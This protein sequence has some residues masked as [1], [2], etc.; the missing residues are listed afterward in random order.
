MRPLGRVLGLLLCSLFIFFAQSSAQSY[1]A[2]PDSIEQRPALSFVYAKAAVKA[3]EDRP[4]SPE[5][6]TALY[7]L[8]Q[9]HL[10]LHSPVL[11]RQTFTRAYLLAKSGS[12][13]RL[14]AHLAGGIGEC[15]VAE[16]AF[17][18][19]L[20]WFRQAHA[21]ILMQPGSFSS[22]F[23]IG[24]SDAN[25]ASGDFT[26]A[27]SHATEALAEASI[28]LDVRGR[29]IAAERLAQLALQEGNL[30]RATEFAAQSLSIA[31]TNKLW[32]IR[33]D[34]LNVLIRVAA[35]SGQPGKL[36]QLHALHQAT[37]D[38]VRLGN[39]MPLTED[40]SAALHLEQAQLSAEHSATKRSLGYLMAA[41]AV[42]SIALVAGFLFLLMNYLKLNRAQSAELEQMV[43]KKHYA[44]EQLDKISAEFEGRHANLTRSIASLK[45]V[46]SDLS[47]SQERANTE[48]AD[49]DESL[50]VAK[51]IQRGLLPS[52]DQL[53]HALADHF[54]LYQPR[55]VVSGDLYWMGTVSGRWVLAALDCTGH[56]VPGAVMTMLAYSQVNQVIL[57]RGILDPGEALGELH[58][59]IRRMLKQETNESRD[60]LDIALCVIDPKRK[61]LSF[62]GANLP[63]MY[64]HRGEIYE[65]KPDKYAVGG[66]QHETNRVYT[67]SHLLYDADYT[68]Y[69]F[70]DG[71]YHQFGGSNRRKLSITKFYEFIQQSLQDDLAQQGQDLLASLNAWR[72]EVRQVDDWMVI[73]FRAP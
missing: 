18:E 37:S 28:Q 17:A 27:H 39:P 22:Q 31:T 13:R 36:Q 52:A 15:Y 71:V 61:S 33:L 24:I 6:H 25:L 53:A 73:G 47:A 4:T 68:F 64:T 70:S 60:G 12:D 19:S 45:Q 23:L 69:M 2:A 16:R 50:E 65:L 29:A 10:I 38:S 3:L 9:A 57:G 58:R 11:A 62:A 34:A 30:E 43:F 40:L 26:A 42:L 8:G 46:N 56:G 7:R 32:Q 5:F 72:G 44:Q 35:Q 55:D 51:S 67:T 21:Y 1:L 20:P 59:G 66:V 54:V 14:L 49:L 41:A 63:L 48:S